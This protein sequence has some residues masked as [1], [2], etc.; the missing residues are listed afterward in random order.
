MERAA[1]TLK[2]EP[3]ICLHGQPS[4]TVLAGQAGQCRYMAGAGRQ[5]PRWIRAKQSDDTRLLVFRILS[6]YVRQHASRDVTAA[7][8]EDL[9]EDG[10]NDSEGIR[11]AMTALA[12]GTVSP[13]SIPP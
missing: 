11:V 2:G 4:I 12:H 13:P 1:R 3:R 7:T 6:S 5:E 10:G 9:R 8:P